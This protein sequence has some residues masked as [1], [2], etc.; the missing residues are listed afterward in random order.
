LYV[1]DF[2]WNNPRFCYYFLRQF[3][4]KRF[5]SGSAQPSLNRN[6]VHPAPVIVPPVAEQQAI[7][8]LLGALDDKIEL[9]RRMAETLEAMARALFK[10]W[11]VDFD[12]VRA[13]S[14]GRP[15]G[16][17]ADLA[18]LFPDRFGDDG[19]PAGWSSTAG[20]IGELARA[21]VE[22]RDVEPETP[23]FGLEHFDQRHL[24]IHR[25][26]RAADVDS[27]KMQFAA[28][29]LLFGKLRPYF[30]KVAIAPFSGICSSDIFVFRPVG[31]IPRSF[32]YL[33][34]SESSFVE[35]AS[36]ASH[37]TKMPRADWGFMKQQPAA[38]PPSA[39]LRAFDSVIAPM[40]ASMLARSAETQTLTVLRDTLLPKLISGELR[41]AAAEKRI[42][43]EAAG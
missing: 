41:I 19:F 23:Y 38:L 24:I 37:G 9:N 42:A 35:A 30:H 32:L 25:Q 40:I 21:T 22:P 34:L 17:A 39:L 2:H 1:I 5:N 18:A 36:T 11:F 26:G 33:A 16:L 8:D 31:Q 20:A 10:S 3:D 29:D 6:F 27:V 43:A 15:T 28:G 7:A 14:E 13:K 4:F 12:P